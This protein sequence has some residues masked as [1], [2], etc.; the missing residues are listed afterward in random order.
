MN[1]YQL[2]LRPCFMGEGPEVN[3][4]GINSNPNN[5]D[6]SNANNC[7][8]SGTDRIRNLWIKVLVTSNFQANSQ[9][10]Q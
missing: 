6:I 7:K 10:R 4:S 3:R 5:T 1:I 8:M 9:R 2:W